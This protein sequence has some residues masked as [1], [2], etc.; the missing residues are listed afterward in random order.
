[1]ASD[2]EAA[3][4]TKRAEK[5]VRT[6]MN[7]AGEE[8]PRARLD[9]VK[10]RV[11]FVDG[12]EHVELAWDELTPEVQ[13]AAGLYGIMTSVTNTVGQKGLSAADMLDNATARLET[14]RGG[15]WSAEAKQG[16]RT[17]DFVEAMQRVFTAAGQPLSEEKIAGV[18]KT[19]L[20]EEK[21]PVFREK[22]SSD[23]RISAAMAAIRSERAAATLAKAQA[24][25]TEAA[26]TALPSLD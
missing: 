14:I 26:P 25:V 20:D 23:P 6:F 15:A 16:A 7:A 21:G 17:S 1:M 8:S 10:F 12:G 19:L 11:T 3:T 18:K 22:W 5:T 24:R 2:S 13:R 4:T 9:S